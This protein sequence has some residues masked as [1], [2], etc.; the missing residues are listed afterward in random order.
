MS[1]KSI[2]LKLHIPYTEDGRKIVN[3]AGFTHY[4]HNKGVRYFMEK[5][6][7]LRQ[8]DIYEDRG[9]NAPTRH[10]DDLKKGLLCYAR[11]RQ[12]QNTG[13]HA[14]TD[15]EVLTLLQ[16]MY[17]ALIPAALREKGNT[18]S[19]AREWLNSLVSKDSNAGM[20]KSK[21][22]RSPAY[23]K[24]GLTAERKALLKEK[25]ENRQKE[26]IA[27]EIRPSLKELGLLPF[28]NTFRVDSCYTWLG[29]EKNGKVTPWDNSSVSCWERDMFQQALERL[30][31]WESWNANA[32]KEYEK[33]E[34]EL[35]A[36]RQNNQDYLNNW[37][38][39]F[40]AYESKRKKEHDDVGFVSEQ[41][42][43][44]NGRMLRGWDYIKD[45]WKNKLKSKPDMS[46]E[47]LLAIAKEYQAKRPRECG[48]MPLL[49]FLASIDM[50]GTWQ[51]ESD[52][53]LRH[54]K[55]NT[56][57]ARFEIKHRYTIMTLPDPLKHPLWPRLDVPEGSNM[58]D[59]RLLPDGKKGWQVEFRLLFLR[60]N[61]QLVEQKLQLP[62][63]PSGQLK[64]AS[65]TA[66][67]DAKGKHEDIRKISLIDQG[68]KEQF[69]AQF[70]GG[71]ICLK[72][73]LIENF[74][75]AQDLFSKD[76]SPVYLNITLTVEDKQSISAKAFKWHRSN[77]A[78]PWYIVDIKDDTELV[79]PEYA[80]MGCLSVDLGVRQM[81]ACSV[82]RLSK[83][84]A[85]EK[86]VSFSVVGAKD[87]YANSER[88]F[89]LALPGEKS[90]KAVKEARNSLWTKLRRL[91]YSL[92]LINQLIRLSGESTQKREEIYKGLVNAFTNPEENA[93]P[94]LDKRLLINIESKISTPDED[95]RNAVINIHMQW[96]VQF[97]KELAGW[98]KQFARDAKGRSR[99]KGIWGLSL[100]GI[101]Y[102]E[103]TRRLLISWT[104]HPRN[105][106]EVKRL[107]KDKLFA[108]RLH[109]HIDGL[110]EDRIKK[111]ADAIVMS[112]LGYTTGKEKKHEKCSLILFE[113]LSRYRFRTDRPR[114]ENK[115]LMQ[116]A[117]RAVVKETANQAGMYGIHV[118]LVGAGFSSRYYS[119][120]MC[121]GIRCKA[122][123]KDDFASPGIAEILAEDK[124]DIK[125]LKPGNIVPWNGG[126]LFAALDGKK[127]MLLHADINAAINLQRRFWT[128]YADQFRI[129]CG[130]LP[131]G[132]EVWFKPLRIGKRNERFFQ[133]KSILQ[134]PANTGSGLIGIL[135][136]FTAQKLQVI[137]ENAV[138]DLDG[139]NESEEDEAQAS[140]HYIFFN[141]P[142]GNILPKER[143]YESKIFWTQVKQRLSA[144]LLKKNS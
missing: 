92:K 120:N 10:M 26:K 11:A 140:G 19:I 129:V 83:D 53:V 137:E 109:R 27:N 117:H 111:S 141:D 80:G 102:L 45:K 17:E 50:R 74:R 6:L 121:P 7:L 12:L 23:M 38:P 42:F 98:R 130:R 107:P 18:Q 55:H 5:L 84:R 105:A 67:P 77:P 43:R 112:T 132:T 1:V 108:V 118:G 40:T 71:R 89:L 134:L 68:T 52:I 34:A 62:V 54:L 24:K 13:R 41:T 49:E 133:K 125:L 106:G 32:D 144:A 87:L 116:W 127:P 123:D 9:S 91:K 94:F 28:I 119:R 16:R 30:S 59:Y 29:E 114:Y 20:G 48:D 78:E 99:Y 65:L 25:Y 76:V 58:N 57:I 37:Q 14:G 72:R 143:W 60:G 97:A 90:D 126:E 31:T 8:R 51:G 66:K 124:I 110:K 103:S 136:P 22:G 73:T 128:Y 46:Q 104:T 75:K 139:L 96:E 88:S 3:A 70:G 64:F 115:R 36:W 35:S 69:A 15:E 47:D 113:D 100:D 86:R 85:D 2:E 79:K 4:L 21:S 33:A 81:A 61:S 101:E 122:L 63:A 93:D 82:F 142:S 95:W 135:R 138:A 44:I 56:L 39:K 131:Q